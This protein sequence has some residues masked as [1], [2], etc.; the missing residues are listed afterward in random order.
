VRHASYA[1]AALLMPFVSWHLVAPVAV[2]FGWTR[3]AFMRLGSWVFVLLA[4]LAAVGDV[5]HSPPHRVAWGAAWLVAAAISFRLS[6]HTGTQAAP[7]S[8]GRVRSSFAAAVSAAR[9]NRDP[10]ELVVLC[11]RRIG[12]PVD[13]AARLRVRTPSGARTH[14]LA[15]AAGYVWWI[16]LRPWR[17]RL[18]PILLY[19][20]LR[21]LAAHAE[22]R[23][24]GSH[25]LELSW[26]ASGELFLGTLHGPG[27]NRL[28]GQLAAEQFAR[29]NV[30]APA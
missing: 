4:V 26:P 30:S 1:L 23:R 10:H 25:R 17:T 21:G 11:E 16:E 5:E 27:A 7:G 22:G 15:L 18:G 19:R 2:L 14:A 8:P 13:A 24:S 28:I 12:R 6:R 20:S 9:P 29:A 3:P